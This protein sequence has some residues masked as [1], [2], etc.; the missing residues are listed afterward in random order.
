MTH[1]ATV[2]DLAR[3]LAE[4]LEEVRGGQGVAPRAEEIESA[5]FL[6]FQAMTS[7]SRDYH[8]LSHLFNVAK[9]LPALA[10]LAAIYHDIVYFHVDGGYPPNVG[11]RIGDVVERRDDRIVLATAPD[12]MVADQPPFSDSVPGRN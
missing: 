8:G 4:S 7:R 3:L 6:V 2:S 1:S 10:R 12:D 5:T 9:S 11:E